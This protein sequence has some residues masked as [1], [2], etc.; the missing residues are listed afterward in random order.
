MDHVQKEAASMKSERDEA[1][2]KMNICQS[3][4][5][6]FQVRAFHDTYL[7]VLMCR[8]LCLWITYVI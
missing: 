2:E 8:S 1:M 7:L 3:R 4:F 6:E 5:D